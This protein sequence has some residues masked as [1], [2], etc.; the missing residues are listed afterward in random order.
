MQL[1]AYQMMMSGKY[2]FKSHV[3][4]WRRKVYSD[5][6]DKLHPPAGRSRSLGQRPGAR[7]RT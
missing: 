2:F 6:E 3:L 5:W 1:V 7:L 4:S